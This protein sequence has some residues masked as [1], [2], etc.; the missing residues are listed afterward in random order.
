MHVRP[1]TPYRKHVCSVSNQISKAANAMRDRAGILSQC[2]I[3]ALLC[4]LALVSAC[5]PV[6]ST[7]SAS[8]APPPTSPPTIPHSTPLPARN[9]TPSLPTVDVPPA[10]G[11]PKKD[12]IAILHLIHQGDYS[13]AYRLWD[14]PPDSS[15]EQFRARFTNIVLITPTLHIVSFGAATGTLGAQLDTQ[16]AIQL[17]DG[18]VVTQTGCI[19][20]ERTNPANDDAPLHEVWRIDSA[21]TSLA[22]LAYSD[23]KSRIAPIGAPCTR[24]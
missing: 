3:L 6:G 21:S 14:I 13:Q 12:L 18:A 19:V 9:Q 7:S 5:Q 10:F 11:S 23:E 15:V 2:A 20:M 24:P 17:A 16:L 4:L 22:L 8:F 1:R